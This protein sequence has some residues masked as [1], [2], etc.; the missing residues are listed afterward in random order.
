MK[1]TKMMCEHCGKIFY[2]QHNRGG[3]IDHYTN[4]AAHKNNYGENIDCDVKNICFDCNDI[5]DSKD[6]EERLN[7]YLKWDNISDETKEKVQGK[8]TV[9]V[10]K[11]IKAEEK[12]K[13]IIKGLTM[14]ERK[15]LIKEAKY[16]GSI[17]YGNEDGE[18]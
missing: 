4:F 6:I 8:C 17:P 16:N 10:D 2:T 9:I 1:E 12:A 15:Y 5:R 18:L 14:L 11:I 7:C 13:H 3:Y